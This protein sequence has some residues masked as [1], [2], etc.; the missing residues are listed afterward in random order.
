[1]MLAT[2]VGRAAVAL[3]FAASG[4]EVP[5]PE[6]SPDEG[7]SGE[8]GPSDSAE[9]PGDPRE[10]ARALARRGEA[11]FSAGRYDEASEAYRD[12]HGLDPVPFFLFAWAR[13][14]QEAGR[15]QEAI[16][17]YQRFI[18]TGPPPEDVDRAN[19]EV[20]RCYG[21]LSSGASAAEAESESESEAESEAEVSPEVDPEPT[22]A[23]DPRRPR[24]PW[25]RDPWGGV[26]LATGV[27]VIS[28]GTGLYLQAQ[29][30]ARRAARARTTDEFRSAS[31]RATV[32]SGGGIA[33]FSVGSALVVGAVVR[34]VVV[35][36]RPR[37]EP[38]AGLRSVGL[39]MRF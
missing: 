5:P 18:A 10:R 6:G 2:I 14:E 16:E 25:L 7:S 9:P 28:V 3:A 15:C 36:T 27:A 22:L 32:L 8:A 11:S 19:L 30:D 29:V 17:L 38:V 34:Y 35:G 1:M 37:V 26:M 39:R 23:D 12:A 4:P 31:R 13:S 24:A 21:Q 20:G 33:G